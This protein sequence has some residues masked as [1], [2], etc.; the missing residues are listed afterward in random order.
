MSDAQDRI[1]E[2]K[3]KTEEKRK[4]L[5]RTQPTARISLERDSFSA[6]LFGRGRERAPLVRGQR[7]VAHSLLRGV[8]VGGCEGEECRCEEERSGSGSAR[9]CSEGAGCD[10]GRQACGRQSG[11]RTGDCGAG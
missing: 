5:V 10:G 11:G 3:R 8:R 2:I 9:H 4:R 7:F 6:W 1:A